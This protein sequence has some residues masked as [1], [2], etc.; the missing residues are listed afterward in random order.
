MTSIAVRVGVVCEGATETEF[1]RSCLSP[2]LQQ[3]G[4]YVTPKDMQG[5]VS[6]E[7]VA[8]FMRNFAHQFDVVTTFLDFYG[9]KYNRSADGSPKLS[10]QALE[11]AI[12]QIVQNKSTHA[13]PHL[14]P[15]IQQYEFEALL[16]SDVTHFDWVL[17]GWSQDR[18]A[19]LVQICQTIPCPEDIN[20]GAMTAPSK[21]LDQ[22]FQGDFD[23]VEH[24]PVIA[25]SIGLEAIRQKCPR[26]DQWVSWLESLRKVQ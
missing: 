8:Q 9:F 14:K 5:N 23:K 10:I 12:L 7:R 6:V 25:E 13:L 24:G 15:Y 4:V 21:R 2:H 20:H 22:I 19:Q 26:F 18:H 3:H 16:F 17:D 11:Q 1:V